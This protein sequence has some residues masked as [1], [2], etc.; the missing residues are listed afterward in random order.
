MGPVAVRTRLD[1][2]QGRRQQSSVNISHAMET[3]PYVVE[4]QSDPHEVSLKEELCRFWD[5]ERGIKGKG[6]E[7]EF[8]EDYLSKV[9]FNG[10]SHGV[11][12]PFKGEHPTIPDNYLLARNRLSYSLNR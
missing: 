7:D 1:Y 8:Y 2:V 6:E 10:R 5:Y 9:K 3:E 4:E 11:S 12:S